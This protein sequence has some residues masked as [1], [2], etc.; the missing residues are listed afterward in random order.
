MKKH[1]RLFLLLALIVTVFALTGCLGGIFGGKD[2]EP[3]SGK[4]ETTTAA[5][6][7]VA[8][9][10][11]LTD[12]YLASEGGMITLYTT[13]ERTVEELVE[14]EETEASAE[15][16]GKKEKNEDTEPSETEAPQPV[17]RQVQKDFLVS[18]LELPRGTQV[19]STNRIISVDGSTGALLTTFNSAM[20][21]FVDDG[22]VIKCPDF[23]AEFVTQYQEV[24]Y[25]GSTYLI[26]PGFLTDDRSKLI[27]EETMYVRT[28]ATIYEDAEGPAIAS[29][30]RK[31]TALDIVDFDYCLETGAV[32]KYKV[33][34]CSD[35]DGDVTGWVYA[36][37]LVD[38][39]EDADAPYNENGT[40]DIH[41]DRHYSYDLWGGS[42]ATLDY[43]PYER[44]TFDTHEMLKDAMCMYLNCAAARYCDNY[45]EAA[46][47]FG[48]NSVVVDLKDGVLAYESEVAREYCP[49]AYNSSYCPVDEYAAS[50][51]QMHDAGLY[52]I[53]RIVV[54]NDGD[55]AADYWEETIDSV[56]TSGTW[57]SAFSRACWEYNVRLAQEAIEL[58]GLDEIQFDYVRFPESSWSIS[59][60]DGNA[61]FRNRYGEE[62]AEGV[63][64]FLFYATDQI[65]EAGAY[66][67]VDV[68][69]EC[70]S[71][72]V[73]A[74]GQYWPAIS[75]IVDAVSAM[76]YTDHY[77]RSQDTWS[78]PYS[79]MASF[80]SDAAARQEEI[81]T[82][83]IPRTWV[84]GYNT[85]YWDP[86]VFYGS[87]KLISQV[88]ALYDNG[89][90]GGFIPWNGPSSLGKYYDYAGAW[91]YDY[92]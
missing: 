62:K 39:Q 68:F 82:P 42:P 9:Q 30:A 88:Q 73:T 79:I 4:S 17:Y 74:Y 31:G 89:L 37:Y 52:V 23:F 25:D 61:N 90:T 78:Y 69:G 14:T 59:E 2:D 8:E 40:F 7:P 22:Y 58:F 66:F 77:G 1:F 41:K 49:T 36:K 32:H 63:Q 21:E 70:A 46:V 76:P 47:D 60:Y 92:Q 20:N 33:S 11:T 91:S 85:P 72:Y 53:G 57:P 24:E 6:K 43:Y 64:N 80:A 35:V 18:A 86:V 71:D 27:H 45:V 44:T 48:C 19:S 54:F 29:W 65:H 51:Q 67:S 26:L 16:T 5:P 38:N 55:F 84:T 56:Y 15:E 83:G 28:S 87:D 10:I 3:E 50:I 13:E 34:F 12:A 81:P 75:N